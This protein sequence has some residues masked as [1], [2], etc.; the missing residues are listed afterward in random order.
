MTPPR[1]VPAPAPSQCI[2]LASTV[3]THN[4]LSTTS[5]PLASTM[6][7]DLVGRRYIGCHGRG[8]LRVGHANGY[9]SEVGVGAGEEE[10]EHGSVRGKMV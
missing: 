2:G 4:N 10:L 1:G 9:D 8:A 3:C 7:I 6:S 5:H